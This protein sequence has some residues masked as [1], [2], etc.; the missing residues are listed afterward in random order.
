MADVINTASTISAVVNNV[1]EIALLTARENSVMAGLVKNF[2]GLAGM[3][4]RAWATYTSNTMG[5]IS[6]STD[7]ASASVAFTPSVAGTLT[8]SI[9]SKTYIMT[10]ARIAS[11]PFQV[12]ADAGRD[13]GQLAAVA[14]DKALVTPFATAAN[15]TAGT[16]A[17]TVAITWAGVLKQAANLKAVFAP[18]PYRCVLNPVQWYDLSQGTPP[19]LY[20]SQDLMSRWG[21]FY[22]ASWAGID[23]FTDGNI[24][25]SPGAGGG[26]AYGGLFSEEAI[27]LDIRR[28]LRIEVQR[29]ASLGGGAYELNATIIFA[30]GVY[31]PT[32]GVSI[33]GASY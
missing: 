31:R 32:F 12:S 1:W 17:G 15:F 11:D 25:H 29:D 14:I 5:T 7:A 9:Y 4:G 33:A 23:F 2:G 16:L 10:D 3:N 28:A 18:P 30:T 20:L 24:T 22:Q 6:E 27:A 19:P 13:L 8:P 26:T 21:G